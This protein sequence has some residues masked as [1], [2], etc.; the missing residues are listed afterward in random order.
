MILQRDTDILTDVLLVIVIVDVVIIIII[1]IIIIIWK[2][3]P[4]V[5]RS[6]A[7]SKGYG[8]LIMK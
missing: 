2:G 7:H 3:Q 8:W 6:F 1:I 4:V 5:S